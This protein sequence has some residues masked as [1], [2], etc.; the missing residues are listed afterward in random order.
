[1]KEVLLEA[2]WHSDILCNRVSQSFPR[3]TR[4]VTCFRIATFL[5]LNWPKKTWMLWQVRPN[6]QQK[7][8]TVMYH[9]LAVDVAIIFIYVSS[10]KYGL[11]TCLN[12]VSLGVCSLGRPYDGAQIVGIP[13]STESVFP[14]W[15]QISFPFPIVATGVTKKSEDAWSKQDGRRIS[16][17]FQLTSW[18]RL[19]SNKLNNNYR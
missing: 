8:E 12:V 2:R 11:W 1:M 17:F 14:G 13:L 4:W 6:R 15:V 5:T 3:A 9:R 19:S 16:T 7:E 10:F 18:G